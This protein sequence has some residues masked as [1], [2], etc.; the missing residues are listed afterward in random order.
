VGFRKGGL[1]QIKDRS[2][3]LYKIVVALQEKGLIPLPQSDIESRWNG[4]SISPFTEQSEVS[5]FATGGPTEQQRCVLLHARSPPCKYPFR[6]PKSV[7]TL[8]FDFSTNLIRLGNH[9]KA[10]KTLVTILRKW[11]DRFKAR[12]RQTAVARVDMRL[13]KSSRLWMSVMVEASCPSLKTPLM[14]MG[15]MGEASDPKWSQIAFQT[16]PT[17][18]SIPQISRIKTRFDGSSRYGHTLVSMPS[19]PC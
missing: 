15:V 10:P 3:L 5:T 6:L 9:L 16:E 17:A 13:S 18:A 8:I 11:R 14:S 19:L 1:S 7:S 2:L 12:P 4:R